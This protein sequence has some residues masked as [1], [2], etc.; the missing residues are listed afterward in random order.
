MVTL[1]VQL[2]HKFK[3]I[4][5]EPLLSKELLYSTINSRGPLDLERVWYSTDGIFPK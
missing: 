1:Q 5:S 3:G 2:D 4:F